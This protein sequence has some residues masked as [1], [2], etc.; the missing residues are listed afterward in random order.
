[1]NFTFF[2]IFLNINFKFY[3]FKLVNNLN[4]NL[5]LS[6]WDIRISYCLD[7]IFFGKF[8]L[9]IWFLSINFQ[10]IFLSLTK[11]NKVNFDQLISIKNCQ[12]LNHQFFILRVILKIQSFDF[13]I[14]QISNNIFITFKYKSYVN[15]TFQICWNFN[16]NLIFIILSNLITNLKFNIILKTKTLNL[17]FKLL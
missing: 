6:T 5:I 12:S 13:L 1:M 16:R 17:N 14:I 2:I 15:I 11:A 3:F 8:L 4:K 9:K 10:K 7:L